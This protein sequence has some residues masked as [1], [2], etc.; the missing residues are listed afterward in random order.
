[1]NLSSN[2]LAFAIAL[3]SSVPSF[4]SDESLSSKLNS[5]RSSYSI[6]GMAA[7][8]SKDGNIIQ[9]EVSGLRKIDDETPI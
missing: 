7:A 4:A 6:P 2:V 8:Y 9:T 1:M 3:F 5:I